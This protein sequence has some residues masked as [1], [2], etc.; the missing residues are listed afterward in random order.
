V[1]THLVLTGPVTIGEL[2]VHLQRSQSVVSDIVGHLVRDGYLDRAT[3]PADRR[4]VR[5]WLS[6]Q[7]RALLDRLNRVLDVP[8]LDAA[9][10]TIADAD[11]LIRGLHALAAQARTL[12]REEHDHDHTDL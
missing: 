5:V 9:L 2:A 4:R 12:P 6:P 3:D 7:G 10:A 8:L 1:L 11:A